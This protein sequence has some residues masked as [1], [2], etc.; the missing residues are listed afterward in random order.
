VL[1]GGGIH[2]DAGNTWVTIG[3][4]TIGKIQGNTIVQGW[5]DELHSWTPTEAGH[6]TVKISSNYVSSSTGT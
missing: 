6:Y 1:Q 3:K 4:I 5:A 2:F